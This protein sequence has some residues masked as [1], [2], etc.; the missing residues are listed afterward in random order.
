PYSV[1]VVTDSV[2]RSELESVMRVQQFVKSAPVFLVICVDWSRQDAVAREVIGG[3]QMNQLS[4]L[5]IGM[6]DASI[7]AHQVALALMSFGLGTCFLANPLLALE[8]SARIL[9]LP[10]QT[11]MP[12]HVL[13]A[14]YP[15][16]TPPQR[17]RYPP[18]LVVFQDRSW[19]P[20]DE[21]RIRD[22][23]RNGNARLQEED[24][25]EFTDDGVQSWYEHYRVKYGDVARERTWEPLARQVLKFLDPGPDGVGLE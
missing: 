5:V 3:T 20:P 19:L 8:E 15:D 12:L 13:V 17:P 6:I 18:D 23:L 11:C 7:F 10:S 22:Y 21:E 14:G 9:S 25:F 16:Q 1:I 24:Y 2:L 4:R